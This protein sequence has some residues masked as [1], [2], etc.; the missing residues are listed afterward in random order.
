MTATVSAAPLRHLV[1]DVE[2]IIFNLVSESL[3][4]WLVALTQAPYVHRSGQCFDLSLFF[5]TETSVCQGKHLCVDGLMKSKISKTAV[6]RFFFFRSGLIW[7]LS[8]MLLKGSKPFSVRWKLVPWSG[9][10]VRSDSGWFGIFPCFLRFR[11]TFSSQGCA[12]PQ[13]PSARTEGQRVGWLCRAVSCRPGASLGSPFHSSALLKHHGAQLT[14]HA[15]A[16]DPGLCRS[17]W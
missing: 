4:G 6:S 2:L 9:L 8:L 5:C 1:Q 10:K 14:G 15:G 16:A 17:S 11:K 7:G 13:E 3:C 12:A